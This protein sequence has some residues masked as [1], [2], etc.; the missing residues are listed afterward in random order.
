ML[1]KKHQAERLSD[2]IYTSAYYRQRWYELLQSYR[3]GDLTH[4]EWAVQNY[5]LYCLKNFYAN[6]C[7][8]EQS[9]TVKIEEDERQKRASSAFHQWKETKSEENPERQR[10][11]LTTANS[12]QPTEVNSIFSAN[13]FSA[14][15]GASNRESD[16]ENKCKHPVNRLS[17][18]S[19]PDQELE[20]ISCYR[21]KSSL[22]R[23]PSIESY[24]MDQQRW[25]LGA[26]LKRVVGLTD[27][28]PSPRKPKN[29]SHSSITQLSSDSGFE[30]SVWLVNHC[31]VNKRNQI[32][33]RRR[34]DGWSFV[35]PAE[36][37]NS[38][39]GRDSDGY[40]QG[41]ASLSNDKMM[42]RCIVMGLCVTF[43]LIDKHE[44]SKYVHRRAYVG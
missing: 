21:P 18:S 33:A 11:R 20:D 7:D 32:D 29:Y 43:T 19:I 40:H 17:I 35:R 34:F 42:I 31:T 8:R 3:R 28:L 16:A 44:E 39:L 15:T 13:S 4:E 23:H 9:H 24:I 37:I 10:S 2:S 6:A 22:K 27:P 14:A 1:E 38:S 5:Q 30:S 25:T 36:K 26:M 12:Q 41:F